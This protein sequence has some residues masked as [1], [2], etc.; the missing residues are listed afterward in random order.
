MQFMLTISAV[1]AAILAVAMP[2]PNAPGLTLTMSPNATDVLKSHGIWAPDPA[3]FARGTPNTA[4]VDFA[5]QS[6]R[7]AQ[8]GIE[9]KDLVYYTIDT[10]AVASSH[11]SQ[12]DTRAV[13][14]RADCSH[15]SL[16]M[17]ACIPMLLLWPFCAAGC[18]GQSYCN[19]CGPIIPGWST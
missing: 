8:S 10:A 7:L 17:K 12:P 13:S 14:A 6:E 4:G 15:C 19:G 18:H 5:V 9:I 3:A 2:P 1:M 11:E 16:C